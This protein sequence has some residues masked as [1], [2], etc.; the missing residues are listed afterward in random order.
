MPKSKHRVYL[1]EQGK[2]TK[3]PAAG[4]KLLVGEG[5]HISDADAKKHGLEL[6][7]ETPT[8]QTPHI[9][10]TP[11]LGHAGGRV[12][13]T[14]IKEGEGTPAFNRTEDGDAATASE[15]DGDESPAA[16]RTFSTDEGDGKGKAVKAGASKKSA[17]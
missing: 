13:A 6:A 15:L 14:P 12:E 16:G 10:V 7:D 11:G 3:D 17:K 1:D 4:V 8:E 5:G 9:T 2:A